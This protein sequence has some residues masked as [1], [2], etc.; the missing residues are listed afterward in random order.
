MKRKPM[1]LWGAALL[2]AVIVLEVT[3]EKNGPLNARMGTVRK[4]ENGNLNAAEAVLSKRSE[5]ADS[6]PSSGV[7]LDKSMSR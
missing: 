6:K 2:S 3:V 5:N 1:I 4:Q 7:R